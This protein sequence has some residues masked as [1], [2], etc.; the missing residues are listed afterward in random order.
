MAFKGGDESTAANYFLANST[1]PSKYE[2]TLPDFDPDESDGCKNKYENHV[3]EK[4]QLLNLYKENLCPKIHALL[5]NNYN[6]IL[7]GVGSKRGIIDEFITS[8]LNQNIVIV[9]YGYKDDVNPRKILS[10][11]REALNCDKMDEDVIMKKIDKLKEPIFLVIHSFDRLCIKHNK[12]KPLVNK[13]LNR[14]SQIHLLTSVDHLNSPLLFTCSETVT[15]NLVWLNCPTFQDYNIEKSFAQLSTSRTSGSS[16]HRSAAATIM[17]V[18]NV[19][20]NLPDNSRKI[21]LLILNYYS[22]QLSNGELSKSSKRANKGKN[23]DTETES[24]EEADEGDKLDNSG[25]KGFEGYSFNKLYLD[26][27]DAFYVNSE[28]TLRSQL[29]EFID[30]KL[31]RCKSGT[32]GSE[33]VEL[34]IQPKLIPKLLQE[35]R[36]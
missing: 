29:V 34:L 15:L 19:Y 7:Y 36:V 2:D 28:G 18:S 14:S 6:V 21:F 23:E 11:F 30:H 5:I 8:Y 27:M 25:K 22:T 13:I 31:I 24:D 20:D 12:I 10:A 17:A 33:Y 35:L 26:C 16:K 9:F 4:L 3:K 32:D 1:K